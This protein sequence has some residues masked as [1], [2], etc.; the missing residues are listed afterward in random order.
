M[1]FHFMRTFEF[2]VTKLVRSYKYNDMSQYLRKWLCVLPEKLIIFVFDYGY[3]LVRKYH[4]VY[5][6]YKMDE[7]LFSNERISLE[8]KADNIK[9]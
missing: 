5:L 4:R 1:R 8:A 3:E 2:F 9:E 7:F 6:G